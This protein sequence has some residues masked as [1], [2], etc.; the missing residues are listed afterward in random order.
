M[1]SVQL[2]TTLPGTMFPL[3]SNW[4][5]LPWV[6]AA[7]AVTGIAAIAPLMGATM[8]ARIASLCIFPPFGLSAV[9]LF[10]QAECA[11]RRDPAST[12]SG[13]GV[14]THDGTRS[15]GRALRQAGALVC[16]GTAEA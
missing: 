15:Q 1:V 14:S 12:R 7:A 2:G 3:L 16:A 9:Q 11:G 4:T 13:D 8:N 6:S 10:I 5:Q